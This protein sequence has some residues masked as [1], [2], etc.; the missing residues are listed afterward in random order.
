[1]NGA[2]LTHQWRDVIAK[3]HYSRCWEKCVVKPR[4]AKELKV[5]WMLMPKPPRLGCE[6]LLSPRVLAHRQP[7]CADDQANRQHIRILLIPPS[8]SGRGGDL[9]RRSWWQRS[10]KLRIDLLMCT[11]HLLGVCWSTMFS[12]YS[13][14]SVSCS[15]DCELRTWSTHGSEPCG[16]HV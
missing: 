15:E 8:P 6:I 5:L 12:R 3:W 13:T 10:S 14:L 2:W 16:V 9:R 1:M 7:C 4:V 11:L